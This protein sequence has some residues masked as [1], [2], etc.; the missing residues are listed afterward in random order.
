MTIVRRRNYAVQS[1][2]LQVAC[3]A[4]HSRS[5]QEL[6]VIRAMCC[7]AEF[8][9]PSGL[10]RGRLSSM[11]A[12]QPEGPAPPRLT[13]GL[14]PRT[15]GPSLAPWPSRHGGQAGQSS[16]GPVH[17][18]VISSI[19]IR[20]RSTAQLKTPASTGSLNCHWSSCALQDH[21]EASHIVCTAAGRRHT[22]RPRVMLHA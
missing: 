8:L 22:W 17:L 9:Q 2:Q 12:L 16:R 6:V 4:L 13:C 20:I 21:S 1:L 3:S 19:E 5:E 15:A 11:H 7:A 10:H 14:R 18:E